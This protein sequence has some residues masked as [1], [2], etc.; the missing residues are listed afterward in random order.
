MYLRGA[1]IGEIIASQQLSKSNPTTKGPECKVLRNAAPAPTPAEPPSSTHGSWGAAATSCVMSKGG[2]L[3]YVREMCGGSCSRL[4]QK[5]QTE[6]KQL[7]EQQERIA[8]LE[9][10][11]AAKDSRIAS[12]T[13]QVETAWAYE[14]E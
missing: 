8:A 11:L 9:E 13:A 14:R 2:I 12:L 5:T 4:I 1:F 10:Q 3:A 7:T 6:H